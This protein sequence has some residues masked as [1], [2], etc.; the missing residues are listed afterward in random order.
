DYARYLRDLALLKDESP[1]P[2]RVLIRSGGRK[3]TDAY[4]IFGW[5]EFDGATGNY[6]TTFWLRGLR[7]QSEAAAAAV[8]KLD[9][10]SKV[11]WQNE[12]GNVVDPEAVAL[13]A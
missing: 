10:G 4:E 5:P 7:F 3:A 6:R 9:S 12:R 8:T 13:M 1:D 2:L 11:N